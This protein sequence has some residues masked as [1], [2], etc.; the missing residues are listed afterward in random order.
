MAYLNYQSMEVGKLY[1]VAKDITQN[2]Q[3]SN[4][5]AY[6]TAIIQN[7][8]LLIAQ[9]KSAPQ[10]RQ[11]FLN[12]I[13]SN[14]R[15]LLAGINTIIPSS[16][17]LEETKIYEVLGAYNL[18]GFEGQE[19]LGKI[20]L[21]MQTNPNDVKAQMQIYHKEI[22]NIALVFDVFN[23]FS[24]LPVS[25]AEGSMLDSVIIFFQG[26][27]EINNLDELAKVS[28]KW[29]QVL[30]AFALLSRENDRSFRIETVERG[31]I[32]LTLSAVAGIVGAFG[33]ASSKVLDAIKKY[34]E[35]KKLAHEA[36]Q[37]KDGVP[38]KTI[39]DLEEASKLRVKQET[40]AIAKQLLEEYKWSEEME[41]M[42]TV[43][44]AMLMAVRHLITF[45]NKGG[46]VD[47]KLLSKTD[48]NKEMEANLTIKYNQIKQIE[49]EVAPG[50]NKKQ[51]LELSDGEKE[52]EEKNDSEGG[53]APPK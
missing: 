21:V 37:L 38:E 32:I 47:I 5:N 45:V 51:M 29:N 23:V 28:S 22:A 33:V 8:D 31:S 24:K 7:L 14:R 49:G 13:E 42:H 40:K 19:R 10:N 26:D 20:F 50:G 46:K 39:K 48:Q 6:I 30:I 27:A 36:R 25:S 53:E 18:F 1:K 15:S 9:A 43:D 17:P 2:V 4:L 35:I 3:N 16:L 52:E 12:Q 44:T 41:D 34:F 11:G